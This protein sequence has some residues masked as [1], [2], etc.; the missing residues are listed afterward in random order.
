MLVFSRSGSFEEPC[1][2][3]FSFYGEIRYIMENLRQVPFSDKLGKLQLRNILLLS[4]YI[5]MLLPDA[6]FLFLVLMSVPAVIAGSDAF[7]EGTTCDGTPLN[8]KYVNWSKEDNK[9]EL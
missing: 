3:N 5:A 6:L 7:G 9:F 8:F 4:F 2:S 1:T